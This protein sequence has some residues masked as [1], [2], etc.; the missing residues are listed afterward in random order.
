MNLLTTILA[1]IA[2]VNRLWST[3]KLCKHWFWFDYGAIKLL[4]WCWEMA[5]HPL[6]SCGVHIARFLKFVWP[7][8]NIIH[9]W[10]NLT[11]RILIIPSSLIDPILTLG[12]SHYLHFNQSEIIHLRQSFSGNH[13]DISKIQKSFAEWFLKLHTF[14]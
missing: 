10:V 7:F 8:F 1:L 4:A 6:K 13:L 2:W 14:S 3:W 5:K 11:D 12:Y 9:E